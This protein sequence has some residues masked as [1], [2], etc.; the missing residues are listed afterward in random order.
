MVLVGVQVQQSCQTAAFCHFVDDCLGLFRALEIWLKEHKEAQ[1]K[2]IQQYQD[3][4]RC[5]RLLEYRHRRLEM[6]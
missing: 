2:E 3:I 1:V 4:A 6:S 5:S